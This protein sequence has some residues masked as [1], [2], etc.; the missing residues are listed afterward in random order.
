[1]NY[2]KKA[3]GIGV[4]VSQASES[5][6][7]EKEDAMIVG[8]AILRTELF[9]PNIIQCRGVESTPSTFG[10]YLFCFYLRF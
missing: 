6:L 7:V 8:V 5:L 10:V 4:E 3:L 2:G 1:V 9:G